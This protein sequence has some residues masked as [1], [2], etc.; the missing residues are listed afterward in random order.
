MRKLLT[1]LA[2]AVAL[3]MAAPSFA[4]KITGTIRGTVTDPSGAVIAGAKVTVINDAT[5]LTR[6]APTTSAGIFAFAELPVGTYTVRVENAGFKAEVRSNVVLNVAEARAVD[7]TLQ[8]GDI[9]EVVTVEVP[10]VAVKLVGADV[11]G[12]VTGE[13]VRE[14]PLNGRNFMQLTLL[15]PGVNAT[16][17]FNTI[18][19]G[20]SGGSDVSVSGGSVTSNLWTVDGANNND[21]GS[22]R[23]ILVYPSVDA[24]EEF[25]IQRNNY[26]AEFGQSGGAQINLVTRGGSNEWHGSAYYFGRRDELTATNF[27]LKQAG[28][29]KPDLK[30]DDYGGTFGGPIIK[31][32]LHFFASMEW[33]KDKRTSVRSALVP[34]AAM[35]NG[36]FSQRIAG[37][38]SP[39]PVDPLTGQPFP[40]NVIP[41]NRLN[42]AGQ[43]EMQLMPLPNTTPTGGSCNNWVEAVPTPVNWRQENIRMD[44]TINDTTRMMVRWTH[45]SWQAQNSPDG[46]W[47]DDP[48]PVV[49]SDWNQPGRSLVAQ[50]NKNIGSTM[51][52]SL[53]FSY[54]ANKISV[55]RA[56]DEQLVQQ[57]SAAIPTLFPADIKQKGGDAQPGA[58]WGSLGPYGG[59][60]LWNQ[61]PWLNNQDLFVLKDDYS[62]VFGKHFLKIGG[63]VSYN[64]K[65]EEPNNTTL[66]S[67]QVNGAAGFVGPNGYIPNATTGNEIANWILNGTAWSTTEVQTNKSVQQR[68]KD[69]EFYVA[70]TYKA[71]PRVTTD[72]GVRLTH[73]VQP[74]IADDQMGTF[75]PA[76]VN[77]ALGNSPCNGMLYVPGKNPCPAAGFP[78]GADG[79]N[80][81]LQPT[82]GLL[83]APRL[84][85]AWDVFGNGKTAVRGGLGLFY[86]RE[87]LSVGLALGTNPPFSGTAAVT[88][89]LNS[90]QPLTGGGAAGFGAP[91]AGIIQEA[92][93]SHNW[94]WNLSV[95]HE[96][97][98]N[99]VLEIAYVGNKGL[100]LL[101]QTNLNEVAPSNRLAYAQ[102]GDVALRPLNGIAQIGDGD[103]PLTTRDRD[104]IY[105]GLQM[106]LVSR[107]GAGSLVSLA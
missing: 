49:A 38:D 61:S 5:G 65:N 6:S 60:I 57:L 52:N 82:K 40:G 83:V 93:N 28:Q 103:M 10:A 101:G 80:R 42:P 18:D 2:V 74:Y 100:D 21:V 59:G 34:T 13:E 36:D 31:D 4:Q 73:F 71:S 96:L 1:F 24:I 16:N 78:G 26:G 14:L 88:R 68:W 53:T 20:L 11:S 39:A 105:H 79:P 81:S 50:L 98:R 35:R 92:G 72:F 23:T 55:A 25:K 58:M 9:S 48:F 7:V 44:W 84:G 91:A 37:C 29:D 67:V 66:E 102:T 89:T 64:K 69:F 33:N 22:N 3:V 62:A 12:L 75:N 51:V 47:G 32:K 95:Q 8:T 70:D 86:A 94:Q 97:A 19:K 30:W 17:G 45:D 41:A 106:Q 104:S 43:L 85:V 27:F 90:N 63:L 107:F 99:T 87:R 54:S 46:T 77:P 76:S 15:Q 56:G